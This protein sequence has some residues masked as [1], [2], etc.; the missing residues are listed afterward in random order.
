MLVRFADAIDDVLLFQLPNVVLI[1]VQM[2][3]NSDGCTPTG[4]VLESLHKTSSSV[5]L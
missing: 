1:V 2:V 3:H 4:K 5:V